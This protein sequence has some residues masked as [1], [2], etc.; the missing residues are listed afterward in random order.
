MAA[1]Q[2][3]PYNWVLTNNNNGAT[4]D[5]LNANWQYVSAG[6]MLRT[7]QRWTI[8]NLPYGGIGYVDMGLDSGDLHA[9]DRDWLH[10]TYNARSFATYKLLL[11]GVDYVS[12]ESNKL[13][14]LESVGPD[15]FTTNGSL[16]AIKLGVGNQTITYQNATRD[17]TLYMGAGFDRVIFEDDPFTPQTETWALIRRD[18]GQID[19]Y[20]LVTGFR[21][22]IEGGTTT[23]DSSLNYTNYG[24]VEN[25]QVRN[26][27]TGITETYDPG[28]NLP[29][30]TGGT[31]NVFTNLDL[32]SDDRNSDGVV[33]TYKPNQT[34]VTQET[35]GSFNFATFNH[36]RY[37]TTALYMGQA[38]VYENASLYSAVYTQTDNGTHNLPVAQQA[39][40]A[41]D[42]KL[43][44][45]ALNM[46]SGLYN[47]FNNV[48][49]GT[50]AAE[51]AIKSG[52][53]ATGDG[54]TY[55][56]RD[57][58]ALYGFG[59]NDT[60]TGGG[61]S[62]YLFGGT[63]TYDLTT[64]PT[65]NRI[66]GGPGADYFGVGNTDTNGNV[67]GAGTDVILD[68]DA[69]TDALR[70]LS[71]GTAIIE[72]LYGVGSGFAGLGGNNTFN[73]R[74]FAAV[75]SG[76]NATPTQNAD[77]DSI[78]PMVGSTNALQGP[79]GMGGILNEASD[80]TVIN[81][82]KIVALG[83]QG[84]DLLLDSPGAD[85]LYGGVGSNTIMLTAGGN[86]RVYVDY[87]F[88]DGLRGA[89]FVGDFTDGNQADVAYFNK[90]IVDSFGGNTG[91]ALSAVDTAG[92]YASAIAYNPA[93][94][95]Y[96]NYLYP[97]YYN[98]AN[99]DTN[100][101]HLSQSNGANNTTQNIGIGLIAAGTVLSIFF[102]WAGA[103]MI[104]AGNALL[105]DGQAHQNATYNANVGAY[106]NVIPR[107]TGVNGVGNTT[108]ATDGNPGSDNVAFTDFFPGSNANDGFIPVIE[109]TAHA[110]Q[111]V[112]GYFAV[113]SANETFIYLVASPDNLVEN[114]EALKVAE[115]NGLLE[116]DDF[117]IYNGNNDIYNPTTVA[118]VEVETPSITGVTDSTSA[119]VPLSGNTTNPNP[120]NV[121][122]SITAGLSAGSTIR[123]YDG[124]T[125]LG[126][127]QALTAGATSFAL[128]DT[129]ST[130]GTKLLQTDTNNLNDV[131]NGN[132]FELQD[133]KVRYTVEL[134]DGLTGIITR[135][136]QWNF[137]VSGGS[138]VL[139][140][141]AGT[142][143]LTLSETS[144]FF[145]NLP[146]AQLQNIELIILNGSA[147]INLSLANQGGVGEATGFNVVGSDFADTIVGSIQ[148]DTMQGGAGADILQGG[149]GA[150][151]FQYGSAAELGADALVD[152]GPHNDV[153]EFTSVTTLVDAQLGGVTSVEVISTTGAST[154]TLGGNAAVAGIS[155]LTPG[156][157]TVAN[158]SIN[159]S[160]SGGGAYT[161]NTS[162]GDLNLTAAGAAGTVQ[163]V[164][165]STVS[166]TQ[167]TGNAGF[168][169]VYIFNGT[170]SQLD[171]SDVT[172]TMKWL[173]SSTTSTTEAVELHTVDAVN[174]MNGT[175]Y[176]V[177]LSTAVAD[178]KA[179]IVFSGGGD[180]AITLTKAGAQDWATIMNWLYEGV[181][182]SATEIAISG[183]APDPAFQ[184]YL[185]F[186]FENSDGYAIWYAN[187]ADDDITAGEATLVG[188]IDGDA[189][190]TWGGGI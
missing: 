110:G 152:G 102:G 5:T 95:I 60:L 132:R 177:N 114:S 16:Y 124:T 162:T 62:D 187:S 188:I 96:R 18:P 59:G 12:A 91:R 66:T 167:V 121:N 151:T 183:G 119:A 169:D 131:V 93:N 82:G 1:I 147:G 94:G 89:Q 19:A 41:I 38:T 85:Y 149:G 182:N 6:N 103:A 79:A 163:G 90:L 69:G 43:R 21:V 17:S 68:W 49:L 134:T 97:D 23:W 186:K 104:A 42:G 108:L 175:E 36:I 148:N 52:Y 117:A 72:G 81:E 53:A 63:S 137:T 155:T 164:A 34:G 40:T 133:S 107:S 13:I 172:A 24:E 71:N 171:I 55:L 174:N 78:D 28:D 129:R 180:S 156:A 3:R 145:N 105:Q 45:Y 33:D 185:V 111:S 29:K 77:N 109:F 15:G 92:S 165:G 32:V 80:V 123:L 76:V 50:A 126:L 73:L 98:P 20:N 142:D 46:A 75:A 153:I 47:Y 7:D 154:V 61:S 160:V 51:A 157:G 122:G 146:D 64:G 140:G 113:Q 125:A 10:L 139:D 100:A 120:L 128:S 166:G 57:R 11:K 2:R 170:T 22:R 190:V 158:T 48:Y 25:I 87:L 161:I 74:A 181:G 127:S 65:G 37:T 150:D 159:L 14:T 67:S 88:K 176:W 116:A 178:Q 135:S 83:W 44:L 56:P 138:T 35:G 39:V 101:N 168:E 144:S 8:A 143:S 189:T 9:R 86:D 70:I 27:V 136:N 58:V 84:N 106:L 4:V 112:Y 31:D 30:V 99:P 118:A 173:S 130:L 179:V 54:A 184:G 26:S 141:G 115:I